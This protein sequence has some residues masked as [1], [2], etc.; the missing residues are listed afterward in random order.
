LASWLR[1]C[2]GLYNQCLE[3]RIKAYRRRGEAIRYHRQCALL[4]RLRE[5]MPTLAAV[6][7]IF[8]R[9]ALRRVDRGF[10]AFFPR[11]QA[12][13]KPGLLRFRSCRRSNS[14]EYLASGSSVR[15]GNLLYVPKLGLV[16]FRAGNQTI[17]GKQKL[18]RLIR[19]ASGWFAQIVVED[20][21]AAP[22]KVP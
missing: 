7:A 10:Q 8:A 22:P 5:R 12:G 3:Q 13:E 11:C 9:D 4:T 18:L 6:P 14:L 17:P 19:R 2:C 1:T 15:P 21:L 16:H 20:G